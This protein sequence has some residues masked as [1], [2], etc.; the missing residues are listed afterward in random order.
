[1]IAYELTAAIIKLHHSSCWH[2]DLSSR[3][4]F[5]SSQLQIFISDFNPSKPFCPES[6]HQNPYQF[7]KLY[8]CGGSAGSAGEAGSGCYLAP[9]RLQIGQDVDFGKADLF[10]L[11]CILGEIFGEGDAFL[12]FE[13][14]IALANC[15]NDRDYYEI[16]KYALYSV[17]DEPIAN[18]IKALC[19]P[20]P[21]ER[22][23]S[24]SDLSVFGV[25][26][27]TIK[28]REVMSKFSLQ[29]CLEFLMD[30]RELDLNHRDFESILQIALTSSDLLLKM[31]IV[32]LLST[33]LTEAALLPSLAESLDDC[34]GHLFFRHADK[35]IAGAKKLRIAHGMKSEPSKK[36]DDIMQLIL[37]DNLIQ[38]AVEV[39]DELN[40]ST[41][42]LWSKLFQI[43]RSSGNENLVF[44]DIF[45]FHAAKAATT[46]P[47]VWNAFVKYSKLQVKLS[48]NIF[49]SR[50]AFSL[51]LAKNDIP[52]HVFYSSKDQTK[53]LH[54]SQIDSSQFRFRQRLMASIAFQPAGKI[55]GIFE[56]HIN[57]II[58]MYCTSNLYFWDLSALCL[59]AR[60]VK[61]PFATAT[62]RSDSSIKKI[63][64]LNELI[65]IL[66]SDGLLCQYR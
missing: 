3:K 27:S 32:S 59:A 51:D 56:D 55:I 12:C 40:L 6:S 13:D 36:K 65:V 33:K 54:V 39:A 50:I 17:T 8:Y 34:F 28:K 16:L 11:G 10:S 64:L 23:L 61:G 41:A 9:E 43:Y 18:L 21:K 60:I 57:K 5:L 47:E 42:E 20:C 38:E 15:D 26:T 49:L 66:Y 14:T 52:F 45:G 19:H 30:L 24:M 1:M 37:K 62:P 7:F 58:V 48:K 53:P 63:F 35:I 44:E 46:N 22:V 4:V 29:P 25:N 31:H 2:G